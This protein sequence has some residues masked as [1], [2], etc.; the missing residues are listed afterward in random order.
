MFNISNGKGEHGNI[1]KIGE[2]N[3]IT[4]FQYLFY[5]SK[6]RR[7]GHIN[8]SQPSRFGPRYDLIKCV[9]LYRH[10]IIFFI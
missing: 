2:K 5:F 6:L 7:G 3:T 8:P 4:T 1:S 10:E 9:M